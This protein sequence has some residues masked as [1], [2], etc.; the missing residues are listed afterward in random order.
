M[1]C[2]E[3]LDIYAHHAANHLDVREDHLHQVSL[4][5]NR[6][7]KKRTSKEAINFDITIFLLLDLVEKNNEKI[8]TNVLLDEGKDIMIMEMDSHK[9][10]SENNVV[11]VET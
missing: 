6:K 9:G 11:Y 5:R 1:N 3:N 4:R 2:I 10:I 7:Q 8:K